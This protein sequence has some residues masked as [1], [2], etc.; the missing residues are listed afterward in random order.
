[1]YTADLAASFNHSLPVDRI[2]LVSVGLMFI[3]LGNFMT[4]VKQNWTMGVR[5]SWTVLDDVVWR[6]SN[7][8]GASMFMLAG[9]LAII[10]VALPQPWGFVML[11]APVLAMLPVLY[12]YSFL[13]YKKRHPEDMGRPPAAE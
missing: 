3:V 2:T 8:L 5:F 10:G 7:R 13:E 11:L 6:K 12:V 4:T 1:M 9:A